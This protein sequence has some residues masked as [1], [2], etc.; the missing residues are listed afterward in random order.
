MKQ[1]NPLNNNGSILLRFSVSGKRYSFNPVPGGDYGNP[2][3]LSTA[4]A[5]AV[6]ISNDI[7]SGHFDESL[8]SYRVVPK[9]DNQAEKQIKLRTLLELWDLWVDS[10]ELSEYTKANHYKWVRVMLDRVNPALT[11]TNWL[12][13]AKLSP[14]TFKDR[15]SLMRAC[16]K[17]GVARGY[18]EVNPYDGI[19]LRKQE[20]KEIKPFTSEEITKI[21]EGFDR[22]YPHY[23]PFVKFLLATGVRTSEAIGLRWGHVD[24][25]RSEVVIKESLPKDL[26]GNGY[27]RVR[28]ETKTGNIRYL[29]LSDD[30][31]SLL[32]SLKPN[33]VKPDNLVFTS[34]TGKPVA[35]DNFRR[36]YWSKVLEVQ[37]IPYRHPYVARHTMVSHAIDQ[38]IPITG[39]A[40]LAGH[41]DTTMIM[42]VYGHRVNRPKLPEIP[43]G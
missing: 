16:G 7:I 26:T 12:T 22:L 34:P 36:R 18:L 2:R 10:L 29:P 41:K 4:Q 14:R 38:G 24:F 8:N 27:T 15:L 25:E 11:D 40:Y 28:K 19:K 35:S 5:I 20:T 31:R 39:I 42:K 17:W 21:I 37:G 33:K 32:G 30:L 13:K 6:R 23:S 3:D 9:V 43:I 1:I